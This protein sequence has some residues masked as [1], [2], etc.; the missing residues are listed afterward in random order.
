MT[1]RMDRENEE[2][3]ISIMD[4]DAGYAFQHGTDNCVS[5]NTAQPV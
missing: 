2:D 1:E 5:G 4:L 3:K